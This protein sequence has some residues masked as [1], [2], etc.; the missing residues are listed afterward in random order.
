MRVIH[1]EVNFEVIYDLKY[2]QKQDRICE[3]TTQ[4]HYGT[5]LIMPDQK[6]FLPSPPPP[7]TTRPDLAMVRGLQRV[8]TPLERI[9][10]APAKTGP[11]QDVP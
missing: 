3:L 11:K 2:L 10:T 4:T 7:Q 8:N 1:N 6:P 9:C 5:H